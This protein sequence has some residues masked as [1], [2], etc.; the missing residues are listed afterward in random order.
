MRKRRRRAHDAL[1][2]LTIELSCALA[3][4]HADR[5]LVAKDASARAER[6][7]R[8]RARRV[9][10]DPATRADSRSPHIFLDFPRIVAQR[11]KTR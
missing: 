11:A 5:A 8:S 2:A 1:E 3:P 6:C 10:L 7:P 9:T 4:P